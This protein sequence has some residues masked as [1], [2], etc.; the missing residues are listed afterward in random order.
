MNLN[1]H[2]K[3]LIT[4][5]IWVLMPFLTM[6]Q[7]SPG[8]LSNAHAHLEGISNCTLCHVL[9]Q[10]VSNEK[11]LACHKFIQD[12]IT[13]NEGY[14]VSDEVKGKEC[15]SCHNEHHGRKFQLIRFDT[16]SFDHGKAGYP[17]QGAHRKV[18]CSACH[19]PGFVQADDLV[20][21]KQTYLG[22]RTECL[23]CHTDYHDNTLSVNC[24][25]CHSFES[26]K[27]VPKFNHNTTSFPLKGRHQEVSCEKCH[28]ITVRNDKQFQVFK[29][30]EFESCTDCHK[31][32]HNNKF[33]QDCKKCHTEN[34]FHTIVGL[35]EFNHDR[36]N[37]K[38]EGKHRNVECK[39][40]HKTTLTAPLNYRY[41][42]DCHE[43]YHESQFQKEGKSPDCANCHKVQGFTPSTYTIE[44]HQEN[45]FPLKGAH[46]ATPCFSCHL[47]ENKWQFRNI[48]LQCAQ[49]HSDTHNGYLPEKYYP[50]K[51]CTNCH[52]SDSWKKISFDHSLTAYPLTGSHKK[53]SCAACHKPNG[54]NAAITVQF[55]DIPTNC[56]A[57][58][59]DEHAGQFTN[60]GTVDCSRCHE[61]TQWKKILFDHNQSRF[62]LDGKHVNLSCNACHKP[63]TINGIKTIQ[64]KFEDIRC[65]SC[66]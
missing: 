2:K 18:H 41:C 44:R 32:V 31:D 38:L 13:N 64:Y 57:C 19:Q 7:L 29:G 48:G 4:L 6:A 1:G 52:T 9:N 20:K 65:E 14:H 40:C 42:M 35:S 55:S 53:P 51:A 16:V 47:K 11:C 10:K 17:L 34:S 49:C 61:N 24:T 25:Q 8:D 58:H 33:G 15:F 54:Q 63:A 50:E 36:T 27:T 59:A 23:A 21:R 37:F 56:A 30:I 28:P 45:N 26:F 43:D 22:L 66:H 5:F 62:I 12:R 39:K 60:N 46:L 3:E